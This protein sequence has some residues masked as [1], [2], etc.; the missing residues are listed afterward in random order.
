MLIAPRFVSMS[1]PKCESDMLREDERRACV[2]AEP[3]FAIGIA[4]RPSASNSVPRGKLS[5][6]G[7][8]AWRLR[9]RLLYTEPREAQPAPRGATEV[10]PKIGNTSLREGGAGW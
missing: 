8:G 1:L 10:L 5:A 2:G 9:W 3:R 4:K 7:Q 6:R